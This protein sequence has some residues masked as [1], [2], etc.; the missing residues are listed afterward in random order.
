MVTFQHS[1]SCVYS[2]FLANPHDVRH[3][4]FHVIEVVAVV[5]PGAGVVGD[6]LHRHLAH[7]GTNEHC[8][9]T[10]SPREIEFK[11]VPVQMHR[12]RHHAHVGVFESHTFA[13]GNIEGVGVGVALSVDR[14]VR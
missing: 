3:T 4:R 2:P 1:G 13:V 8:V 9:L 14:P 12:V 7:H 10:R 11:E 6:E 5:K